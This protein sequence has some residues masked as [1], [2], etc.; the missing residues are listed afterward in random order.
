[1]KTVE[2]FVQRLQN[3]PAFEKQAHAFDRGEDLIAFVKL[4]GYDFSLEELTREFERSERL[5]AATIDP[6]PPPEDISVS[7]PPPPAE[8]ES[9]RQPEVFVSPERL[10]SRLNTGNDNLTP[11]PPLERLPQPEETMPPTEAEAEPRAGLFRGGGGRHRGFS[12]QR[13][14]SV[15]GEEP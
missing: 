1:M 14:K 3:D 15:S 8:P 2:E 4:Q 5:A 10:T 12:P 6:A 13:L 7:P 11:E 9:P